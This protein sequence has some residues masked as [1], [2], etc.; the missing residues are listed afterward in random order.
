MTT[1]PLW[2]KADILTPFDYKKKSKEQIL[3]CFIYN[4]LDLL[5]VDLLGSGASPTM[6][7]RKV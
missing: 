6:D 7:F 2:N 5:Q 4:I 3:I 1:K